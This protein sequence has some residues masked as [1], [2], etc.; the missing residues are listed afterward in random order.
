MIQMMQAVWTYILA[1]WT[2]CNQHLHNDA[3]HLSTPDYQQRVRT[4]YERG[5]QLPPAAQVALFWKPLQQ[6]LELP[7]SILEPWILQAHKYMNQQ[8]RA[9]QKWA[10]LHTPNIHSFFTNQSANDLHPL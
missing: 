10:Q 5:R 4:L 8:L 6:M 9:A 2:I 7:P 1:V 3:S